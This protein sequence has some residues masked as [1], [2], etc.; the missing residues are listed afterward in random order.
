VE[1]RDDLTTLDGWL[2][3]RMRGQP[4][5]ARLTDLLL[6]SGSVEARIAT[7]ESLVAELRSQLP[8]EREPAAGHVLLR[9][10]ASGYT[11]LELDG[12]PP[13]LDQPLLLDGHRYRVERTGRSPLPAD[14]RPCLFLAAV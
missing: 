2:I 14:P 1:S 9:P 6:E 7:L 5:A 8:P 12:P 10:S 4:P 3:G 11:L 13:E